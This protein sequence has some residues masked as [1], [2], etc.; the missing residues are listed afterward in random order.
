MW[1]FNTLLTESGIQPA[2]CKL[3]R[4]KTDGP[5]GKTPYNVWRDD[6]SAFE[7]YQSVQRKQVFNREWLA[8]FVGPPA[9][10][11]LF[12]GLYRISGEPKRNHANVI[13][14]VMDHAFNPGELWVYRLVHDDRLAHFEKRLVIEWGAGALAW[15]QN[16]DAQPKRLSELRRN[17][18]EPSFPGFS[19]F[20]VRLGDLR[21]HMSLGSR[22]CRR[23]VVFT[24]SYLMMV[25][26][27]SGQQRV[28]EVS[29]SD[30]RIIY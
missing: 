12:V 3:V 30:G 16:A 24:S 4:H 26:S 9:S 27:T 8:S 25:N 14:P 1:S 18:Q 28:T 15:T 5:Q 13:C 21:T 20:R 17:F 10:E 23:S 29:G 22:H 2:L 11:T 19:E 6:P 7:L